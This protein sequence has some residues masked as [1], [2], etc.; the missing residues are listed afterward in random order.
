[1]VDNV[2]QRSAYSVGLLFVSNRLRKQHEMPFFWIIFIYHIEQQLY[3]IGM[4]FCQYGVYIFMTGA[5]GSFFIRG[6][7]MK[8]IICIFLYTKPVPSIVLLDSVS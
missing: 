8:R 7:T 3:I 5:A 1:M 4:L 2:W 6:N